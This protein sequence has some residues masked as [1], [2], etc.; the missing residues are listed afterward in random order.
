[1]G[2]N[3]LPVIFIVVAALGVLGLAIVLRHSVQ[4]P[5]PPRAQPS[6]ADA[7][8]GQHAHSVR[9]EE[10]LQ[11]LRE[12]YTRS[13]HAR[14]QAEAQPDAGAKPPAPANTDTAA[15]QADMRRGQRASWQVSQPPPAAGMPRRKFQH[16]PHSAPYPHPK[17]LDQ[18]WDTAKIQDTILNGTDP[19]QRRAALDF[20]TGEDEALAISILTTALVANDPDP[21]FRAAVVAAFGDYSDQI[22]PDLLDLALHDGAPEV[23]FEALAVL[24]DIDSPA[25]RRAIQGAVNDT[26]PDVRD[27]AQGIL[28]MQ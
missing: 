18:H 5:E 26:D 12:T 25:A 21:K 22:S 6:S 19:A 4:S 3:K 24:A 13:E 1:M 20:L 10:R 23:R 11:L 7:G 2:N 9:V 16:D 28:D 17:I 14:E 27:L 8:A 15:R